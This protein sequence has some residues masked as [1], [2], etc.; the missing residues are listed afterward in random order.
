MLQ[1]DM[2]VRAHLQRGLVFSIIIIADQK[3]KF[4]DLDTG[5][6]MQT[7][8]VFALTIRSVEVLVILSIDVIVIVATAAVFD[9]IDIGYITQS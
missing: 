3:S 7:I 8:A 6:S 1:S 2:L 9:Y 4:L 5:Q